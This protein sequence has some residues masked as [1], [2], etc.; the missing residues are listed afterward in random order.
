[1]NIHDGRIGITRGELESMRGRGVEINERTQFYMNGIT[2][3]YGET[4]V[5]LYGWL[6][7]LEAFIDDTQVLI[8][9]EEQARCFIDLMNSLAS[10]KTALSSN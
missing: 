2:V 9:T 10:L 3:T 5:G 7:G 8:K 4:T 6:D 1:M